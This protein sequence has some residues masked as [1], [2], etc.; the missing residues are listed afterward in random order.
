[1]I[2]TDV[3]ILVVEDSLTQ[4][5]RME[6][7]LQKAGYVTL[8][9]ADA[10][11]AL[12]LLAERPVTLAVSD[13]VMPGMNGYELC[14]AIRKLP[15]RRDLPVILLTT[16]SDPLDIIRGVSCGANA[17]VTKPY[18]EDFLLERVAYALDN[19]HKPCATQDGEPP[20]IVFKGQTYPLDSPTPAALDLLISVYEDSVL[21]NAQLA[22]VNIA[23]TRST[24]ELEQLAR[25]L[26]AEVAQRREVESA[27]RQSEER[28]RELAVTDPLTGLSNRRNFF[29]KAEAEVRRSA[30]HG[31]DLCLVMAD[32][33]HFKN[34]NDTF[35]HGAGDTVL[36]AV[37][38]V[39]KDRLRCSDL[40]ARYGGEEFIMLLPETS[41]QGGEVLAETLRSALQDLLVDTDSGLVRL[42][43]SLGVGTL[44]PARA[45]AMGA[46]AS[47][48]EVITQADQA[49]YQSKRTG[50]NR[51]CLLP[52]V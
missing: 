33:D 30:R 35:G 22:E 12:A 42:T 24:E 7:L 13:I 34:I 31:H 46:Q 2:P 17:F 40:V 10:E 44:L 39:L 52:R 49:L 29:Q 8:G 51:V 6:H 19:L 32:I 4:R 48:H 9:A 47:L 41:A 26:K 43:A 15:G 1:M 28:Y 25:D 21:R 45:R 37:A 16:L 50:R 23:L 27:L 14:R 18:R 20:C 5:M 3:T 38:R 36:Q 11:H